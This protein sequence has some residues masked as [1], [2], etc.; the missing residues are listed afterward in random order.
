MQQNKTQSTS[1]PCSPVK[2]YFSRESFGLVLILVVSLVFWGAEF[3]S[4]VCEQNFVTE[5]CQNCKKWQ[6]FWRFYVFLLI[7]LK[8]YIFRRKHTNSKRKYVKFPTIYTTL[9]GFYDKAYRQRCWL[10][11][12]HI[13][14][15]RKI[16]L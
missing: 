13:F 9:F 1:I 7:T 3:K 6:K 12:I 4:D 5:H 14:P 16:L 8:P 15:C 2:M 10:K 11:I